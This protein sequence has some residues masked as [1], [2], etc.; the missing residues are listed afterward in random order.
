MGLVFG[1]IGTSPIYTLTV[2][3]LLL[4]PTPLNILGIV[5][6]IIWT[7]FLLVNVEYAFLAM[8]LAKKGEGG[9]VVLRSILTPMLKSK[10]S[11]IFFSILTFLGLSLLIGDGVIT[12]A[13]SI[14]SAVEGITLIPQFHTLQPGLLVCLA[15]LIA[16]ALFSFQKKGTEKVAKTFGPIMLCWFSTL[17]ILGGISILQYPAILKAVNPYYAIQF[18]THHGIATFFIL[19]E[20]ILCATGGE[21]LYADMGHLDRRSIL[22]GWHLVF[23]ALIINYLG[24]GAFLITHPHVKN[25]LFGMA[26]TEIH[27]LYIP[28]LI[29]SICATVIAS[30][31][32]ISGTFSIVYQGMNTRII[33]LLKVDY[34]SK[35][36]KSQIYISIVNWFL[37]FFV[38]V[39]MI[40]FKKSD[41][42]AAAYGLA[43]TGTMTITGIMMAAIFYLQKHYIKASLSAFI[44]LIDIAFLISNTTKISHGGYFSLFIASLPL[45]LIIIYTMGNKR[46]YKFFQPMGLEKFLDKYIQKHT[47]CSLIDGTAL[48]F[49]KDIRR[50]PPYICRT[51]FQNGILYKDNI[52]V[53]LNQKEAPYGV[54]AFFHDT[55]LAPGLRVF[56][57]QFGYMEIIN[58]ETILKKAGIHEIAIF[59]GSEDINT[60]HIIWKIYAIIKKLSPD[61]VHFY[62]IPA[63]K[64][65]GVI[66]RV[67][68]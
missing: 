39:L 28:F 1:D 63:N 4:K 45:S 65:N 12:P 38:L 7:L 5:S 36:I 57:I 22:N 31:A 29:L 53:S 68:M 60:T 49:A 21:A 11:I 17:A 14:L 32:L 20:V 46:L 10:K 16:I 3:F 64:L 8:S 42:L 26:Y 24:Q 55:L 23:I 62:K 56:E 35:I 34:T 54:Q 18:I 66:S 58:I 25:V 43:V 50:I 13:I 40:V 19:S 44:T 27:M 61:L 2:I 67:D 30:Q 9:T 51:M 37:L 6:L 33:P 48:F 15:G 52:I 47:T 59:Y 41:N